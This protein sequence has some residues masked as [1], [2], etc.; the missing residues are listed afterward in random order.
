MSIIAILYFIILTF[1]LGYSLARLLRIP[2]ASKTEA[3]VM[4]MGIGLAIFPVILTV[5]SWFHLIHW[6]S[7]LV[8]ALAYPLYEWIFLKRLPRFSK[9]A[10]KFRLKKQHLFLI[11]LLVI[12]IVHLW[13]YLH[14]AFTYPYL[15]D[16]D[17]LHH[18]GA[19]SYIAATHTASVPAD[20]YVFHYLE[21][22]PPFYSGIMGVML[23]LS[24]HDVVWVLKFFNALIISLSIL[25]MYFLVK[26][27]TDS[28]AKAL[29][30]AFLLA[31][32]PSFLSHFIFAASYA[33]VLV[34]VGL[35][36]ILVLQQAPKKEG[37]LPWIFAGAIFSGLFLVQPIISALF[38]AI[39]GIYWL[40]HW[41]NRLLRKRLFLGLVFGL[42][43]SQL[44]WVPAFA[45][46][47]LE[48]TSERLGFGM[49]LNT[50]ANKDNDSSGGVVYGF[51]DY[52]IAPK[53]SKMDQPTGLG[54]ALF[55]LALASI[56]LYFGLFKRMKKEER[57][58]VLFLILWVVLLV[59]LLESNAYPYKF[60]PHRLWAFFSIGV[61]LLATWGT[62]VLARSLKQKELRALFF[63]VVVIAVIWTAGVPKYAV[64]TSY[65][66]PGPEWTSNEQLQGYLWMKDNLPHNTPV[67]PLC[68]DSRKPLSVNMGAFPWD[69]SIEATRPSLVDMTVQDIHSFAQSKGF[70]YLILDT[71][72]INQIGVNATNDLAQ[73]LVS[74]QDLLQVAYSNQGFLLFKVI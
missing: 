42:L 29:F 1:F 56:I 14:G 54:L 11:L 4:S 71:D 28:S 34:P 66:P 23:Q 13:V 60:T 30:A 63:L 36:A 18:A 2:F 27:M 6:A 19:A 31:L 41:G 64:E 39:A 67:L 72:C 58:L 43:L 5:F 22:Y 40:V 38:L 21:P 51:S 62:F 49:F 17:P 32:V 9:P 53:V 59:I 25:F 35:W 61:V 10:D 12:F 48:G 26:R 69:L 16:G 52:A 24:Q 47:G 50:G 15:E 73:T 45:T 33:T 57:L 8:L 65:W 68:Y 55:I 74:R 46:Y 20:T 3:F 37:I 44:F 7:L 70:A